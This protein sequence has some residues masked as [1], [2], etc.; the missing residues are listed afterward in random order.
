MVKKE[1]FSD[2][3]DHGHGKYT[4]F[5]RVLADT[6]DD[7]GRQN[8]RSADI[9]IPSGLEIE[10]YVVSATFVTEDSDDP[11]RG[12]P[13]FPCTSEHNPDARAIA[14]VATRRRDDATPS[15]YVCEFI[16]MAAKKN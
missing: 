1:C 5:G 6:P 9:T 16:V 7:P 10:H 3:I 13:F 2:L 14:V 4:L 15:Q 11:H 8:V 12:K